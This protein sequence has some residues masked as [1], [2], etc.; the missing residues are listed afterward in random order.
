MRVRTAYVSQQRVVKR[1]IM[2]AKVRCER[3]VIQYLRKVWKVA[4]NSADS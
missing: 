1:K 4:G 3:N 2:N